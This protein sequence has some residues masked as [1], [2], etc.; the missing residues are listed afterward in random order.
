MKD[1]FLPILLAGF[2]LASCSSVYRSGQ[3]PDDV[4]YSPTREVV[5]VE[6]KEE[7]KIE[8]RTATTEDQYL[9]M[10]VRN[11]YRWTS[12]DD[13]DYWNDTR[14]NHCNCHCTSTTNYGYSNPYYNPIRYNTWSNPYYPVFVFGGTKTIKT[15][16]SGSNVKAYGNTRYSNT[17]TA[18][19]PKGGSGNTGSGGSLIKK[20]LTS[21]GSSVDRSQRT[22]G[23]GSSSSGSSTSSGSSSAGGKSGGMNTT[24]SG[25]TSGKSRGN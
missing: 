6:E 25:S 12:I 20:V 5:K 3:T 24:G 14:Y 1:K 2:L 21:S 8:D 9:K 10:K 18:S 13:Y 19:N 23:S 17:N 7:E 16:T 4:Y 22:F 15:S 11:R